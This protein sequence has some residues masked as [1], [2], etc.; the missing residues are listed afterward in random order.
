MVDTRA[1]MYN[2]DLWEVTRPKWAEELLF[3]NWALCRLPYLGPVGSS[4]CLLEL[5]P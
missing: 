5:H 1:L 2:L 4:A 3:Q